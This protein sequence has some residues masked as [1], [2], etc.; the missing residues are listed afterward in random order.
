MTAERAE[1][2]A[3]RATGIG[4]SDVAAV[5]NIGYGCRLRLW[6]EKRGETPDFPSEETGPMALGKLLEPYFADHYA[7]ITGRTVLSAGMARHH[8]HPEMLVHVDRMVNDADRG[9]GVLEIKSMGRGAYFNTKRKGLPEDYILQLNHGMLVT[10]ATWG[11]FAIGCR[12][13]GVSRP[14][15]LLWWDVDRDPE[16][17]AQIL[18]EVPVFWA[19]VENGPAPDALE[20]DD[21]RC[22]SCQ[23]RTSCQGNALAPSGISGADS[24]YV[25]DDS[26]TALALEYE[27]RRLLR[28]QADELVDETSAE[29]KAKLDG[30]S[31]VL[32][33][34][35]KIQFNKYHVAAYT[36]KAGDRESLRIYPPKER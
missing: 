8:E 24:E 4:G 13:F 9:A 6:R 20:P 21:R 30:R 27:E 11:S 19:Q 5:F 26:L 17:C 35:S 18:A 31:R 12:D 34:G 14:E 29:I 28:K 33:G 36:V 16:I 2:L 22:Q 7:R 15:D 3:E 25:V 32:A 10:G 23:F 1:F